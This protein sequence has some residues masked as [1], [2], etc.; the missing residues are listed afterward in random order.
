M[1]CDFNAVHLRHMVYQDLAELKPSLASGFQAVLDYNGDDIQRDL[2]LT[3]EI[4]KHA[5]GQSVKHCLVPNGD[6]IP[7]TMENR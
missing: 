7:V 4:C 2:D 6:K 5:F 3:F 1:I